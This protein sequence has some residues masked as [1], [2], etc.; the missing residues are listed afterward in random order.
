MNR[1]VSKFFSG[2]S[3]ELAARDAWINLGFH[4][5]V[6]S[7]AADRRYDVSAMRFWDLIDYFITQKVSNRIRLY[8]DDNYESFFDHIHSDERIR[9]FGDI[10]L[11]VPSVSVDQPGRGTS[12]QLRS[13]VE[14]GIRVVPHGYSHVRLAS[15]TSNGEL[16]PTPIGGPYADR[17]NEDP[18]PARE[19]EV[20]FQLVEAADQTAFAGRPD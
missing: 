8:F 2:L 10:V 17:V 5:I 4:D 7:P 18:E 20:L 14:R 12:S 15:Y 19:N 1:T 11:A 3:H 16:L 13:A 9:E 6:V